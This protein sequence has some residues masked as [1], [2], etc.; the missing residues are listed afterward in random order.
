MVSVKLKNVKKNLHM[1]NRIFEL[2]QEILS[3]QE[4][5][6]I[7]E[8]IGFLQIAEKILSEAVV[9]RCSIEKIS[10]IILQTLQENSCFGV[11]FF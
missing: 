3:N 5:S 9:R 1:V 11:P 10:L 4:E 6:V 8:K 7:L 2:H